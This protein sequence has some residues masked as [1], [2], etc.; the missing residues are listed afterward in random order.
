MSRYRLHL[1]ARNLLHR[2]LADAYVWWR[3]AIQ[4]PASYLDGIYKANV[5]ETRATSNDVNFNP[6]VRLFFKMQAANAGTASQ[7]ATALSAVHEHYQNNESHLRR[8]GDLQG[9]LAA[10]IRKSGGVSGL[11]QIYNQLL[12]SDDPN[13]ILDAASPNVEGWV[14]VELRDCSEYTARRPG[15]GRE[16][17]PKL[18]EPRSH[19]T[20]GSV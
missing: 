7:W 12:D 5:I 18:L 10:F 3:D 4:Q 8:V 11:R 6:I 13:A 14:T 19:G 2:N 17:A 16:A 1:G 15:Y 9:E 20:L